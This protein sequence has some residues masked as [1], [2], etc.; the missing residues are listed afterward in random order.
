MR[1]FLFGLGS[2][3]VGTSWVYVSLNKFGGMAPPL[4]VA[5]VFLFVALLA[6][7]FA[8]AGWLTRRLHGPGWSLRLLALG[9]ALWVL[10][11]WLRSLWV[12]SFPW[13]SLGYSQSNTPIAGV[14]AIGSVYSLSLIVMLVATLSLG[15][16]IGPWPRRIGCG[17]AIVLIIGVSVALDDIEWTEPDG[18]P[19][20]AAMVQAN[21]AIEDKWRA[22][23]IPVIEQAY[24]DM[25]RDLEQADLIVWPEAAIPRLIEN[26][27]PPFWRELDQHPA[28]FVFGVI[29]RRLEAQSGSGQPREIMH[30]SAVIVSDS[31][32]PSIY[33]KDHLVAFGEYVPFG[34]WLRKLVEYMA[35]PM[36]DFRPWHE[37]QGAYPVASTRLG[38][39]ICYEDSFPEDVRRALPE[40]G[41]LV[42]IS[43]DA[44]F[45]DSF[46]PHQ[47]LQMGAI[48]AIENGRPMLRSSNTGV[49]AVLDHRGRTLETVPQFTR[50][51]LMA[52]VQPYKG[53][54]PFVRFGTAPVLILC[55]II[56]LLAIGGAMR[57]RRSRLR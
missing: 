50:T 16:L 49:T 17:A 29:E 32:T 7:F 10:C 47:R 1:G 56:G 51:T 13:L 8:L 52:S 9:P 2:F 27:D 40:A 3:G 45:G 34:E 33:R 4:A 28:T 22:E 39:S 18:E 25:S 42:N 44:W 36:A 20:Q 19:I 30:N 53:V 37:P 26:L 14:A 21:I 57:S 12:V 23:K 15:L 11:E 55:G 24:L 38:I 35:I 43:E 46:G 5:A 54:T 48:R 6:A 41:L 31:A